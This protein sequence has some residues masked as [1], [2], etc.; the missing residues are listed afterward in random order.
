GAA[1]V[2]D[3]DVSATGVAAEGAASVADNDVPTAVEESSIPSLTPPTQP[4]PPSQDILS[5]SQRVKKLE[6][7]N[8]LKASKLRRLNNVGTTQRIETFDDTVMDDVSKH[9]RVI[10]DMDADVDVTLKDIAKD[11]KD[12]EIEESSY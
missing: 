7:R 8:K 12:D 9:G 2:N 10:A 5:T 3:E 1:E 4:P 6:M 11:V